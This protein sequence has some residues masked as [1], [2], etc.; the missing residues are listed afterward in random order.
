MCIS[1]CNKMCR[2]F[3]QIQGCIKWYDAITQCTKR[4]LFTILIQ[5]LCVYIPFWITRTQGLDGFYD[6]TF[7][8]Y[9]VKEKETRVMLCTHLYLQQ[10]GRRVIIFGNFNKHQ[11]QCNWYCY[12]I[13]KGL[14]LNKARTWPNGTIVTPFR[15]STFL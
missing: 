4:S 5:N 1:L 15:I 9:P 7:S 13:L 10:W 8:Y 11:H 6:A 2:K 3:S 14:E 12:E